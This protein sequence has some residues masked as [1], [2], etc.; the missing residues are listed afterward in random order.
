MVAMLSPGSFGVSIH[1]LRE[2]DEK[3]DE[4]LEHLKIFLS[5]P[6]RG[7]RRSWGAP[8]VLKNALFLSTPSARRATPGRWR[9]QLPARISIHALREE[10]DICLD[11]FLNSAKLFLSTPSARRATF[12]HLLENRRRVIS[13]HA[14]RE[15]GDVFGCPKKDPASKISIHALREE[16]DR[17]PCRS[18]CKPARFL[19]TPSARRATNGRGVCAVTESGFLSTPSARRA[20]SISSTRS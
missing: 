11:S 19:S 5:T 20:T 4:R 13:I 8:N 9:P 16:G 18:P 12:W 3:E 7:G 2:G 14:L 10:G 1:A 6:S 17:I 15:E